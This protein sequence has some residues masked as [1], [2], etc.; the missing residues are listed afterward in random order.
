MGREWRGGRSYYYTAERAGGRVAKRY[1]GTGPV[2]DLAAR[3][4]AIQSAEQEA[5]RKTI[6][7]ERERVEALD[8]PL[9]ELD[10]LANLLAQ[11]ALLAAGFRQHHR[12][13]WRKRREHDDQAD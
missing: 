12:G 8:A 7:A 1:V 10:E 2:A 5:V 9:A 3:M 4:E 11:A 6:R 13:E